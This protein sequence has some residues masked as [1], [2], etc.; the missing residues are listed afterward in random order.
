MRFWCRLGFHEYEDVR[1]SKK[2]IGR[3][4]GPYGQKQYAYVQVK[5]ICVHCGNERTQEYQCMT[6][7]E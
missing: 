3:P 7:G 1:N 4:D 5:Q 6:G 2:E